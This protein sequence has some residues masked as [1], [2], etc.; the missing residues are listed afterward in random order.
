MRPAAASA[1]RSRPKSSRAG[2]PLA[3]ACG[4]VGTGAPTLGQVARARLADVDLDALFGVRV[5]ESDGRRPLPAGRAEPRPDDSR[6][7]RPVSRSGDPHDVRRG[8]CSAATMLLASFTFSALAVVGAVGWIGRSGSPLVAV[9]A[10]AFALALTA[11]LIRGLLAMLP[12]RPRA[13]R[14]PHAAWLVPGVAA[15]ALLVPLAVPSVAHPPVRPGPTPEGTVRGFLGT[16]VDNDGVSAC[17]YLT[18]QAQIA[19]VGG[20]CQAF[21][22]AVQLPGI[23]SDA[24]L[25]RLAY[26]TSGRT[27]TVLGRR[28]DLTLA[29]Q[30]E[31]S[32]FLAPPTPWR[33]ASSVRWLS[34]SSGRAVAAGRAQ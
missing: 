2:V 3:A 14:H 28:F 16:V 30:S 27:V 1:V 25:G 13:A 20:S 29:T 7:I 32:G 4:W 26:T 17:R 9:A 22:G 23:T 31:R 18:P 33:I 34:G 21:F 11:L 8:E 6:F 19:S 5:W 24:Q 10:V 12:E 15:A